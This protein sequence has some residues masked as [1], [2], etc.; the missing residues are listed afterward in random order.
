VILEQLCQ[1]ARAEHLLVNPDYEPKPVAGLISIDGEGRFLGYVPTTGT[2][3]RG[4]KLRGKVF[5]VPRREGRT[6]GAIADFLVD[7]SEYVLGIEPDGQPKPRKPEELR[8]R[9]DLFRESVQKALRATDS[10]ALAAVI[11]FLNNGEEAGRAAARIAE[12][13]FA[14]N[15]LFAFDFDGELVHDLPVVQEYFSRTRQGSAGNEVRCLICGAIAT[16]VKKHPLVKVQGGSTS[17]VAIV[18]FNSDAF[19]S[20]GLSRNENAPVCRSCADAYTTALNRL[21]SDRYPDPQTAG[22]TMPKRFVRLSPDT[23]AVFWAEKPASIVE[24]LTN[25]FDNPGADAVAEL[26]LAPHKGTR[27]ADVANRFFC[28]ILSGGQGRATI[29]GM[30]TGSVAQ[31]EDNVRRYFEATNIGSDQPMPLRRLLEGLVLQGKLENLPPGLASD[32]FWA[33]LF[34]G[35]FPQ[36]LLTRAAGR[37][38]AERKVTRE[39]AAILRAYLIRN[40]KYEVTVGLDKENV[41]PGYRLGRLMAVLERVQG[42]AQNN[43][44]KTI[45]D[46]FYGAAS[47]R[48][49]TVFPRLIAL[50]QHHLS[51]LKGNSETFYQKLLGEVIGGMAPPFSPVLSLEQQGLFALGYYHQRQEFFKRAVSET[52]VEISDDKESGGDE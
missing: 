41:Q 31:I 37:C 43:P 28:L 6:S 21:L 49:G 46:R 33:V 35:V 13:G 20:Y 27:P 29:R 30:H 42:Q 17:G 50:A 3:E 11:R 19:E 16:P 52:S 23:T 7:K 2:D 48:P 40:R 51:K 15:D 8:K 34:G 45:V 22:A 38:R 36:T 18:T 26:I 25:F 12:E 5:Q 10:P 1:L 9:M 24:L 47:T 14:S 44:N 4:K 39:R 32:V